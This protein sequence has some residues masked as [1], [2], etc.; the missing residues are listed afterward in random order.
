MSEGPDL[1]SRK[2]ELA[3]SEILAAAWELAR[4]NG[5]AAL[6]LREL[7]AKVGMRAP[8]LYTYF[9]SKND[10]Y[11]AMYAQ[12]MQRFADELNKVTG[13]NPRDT[14]RNLAKTHARLALADPARY[15]LLFHRPLPGFFPKPE[16][17]AI[18]L[19][20]LAATREAAKAAG[21][22]EDRAFDLFMG[23]SRG[24]IALQI[25]NEPGG[26]RWTRLLDEAI[27]M[28]IAHFDPAANRRAGG[29]A[30]HTRGR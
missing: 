15:E 13:R 26:D 23:V 12:G 25:A 4:R 10:L 24:L 19:N 21:L 2:R 6:S 16:S 17:L 8:S 30:A 3:R 9:P 22:G 28:L 27:D 14:F 18:G 20:R 5:V 11:D 7:A 29:R 1:R